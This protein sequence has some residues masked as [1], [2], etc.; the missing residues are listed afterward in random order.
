MMIPR[1]V[2]DGVVAG[3]LDL[4]FRRW[5]RRMHVPGG[6]QRTSVGVISFDEVDVVEADAITEDDARRA[7]MELARLARS[8]PASPA[9]STGSR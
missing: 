9:R 8:W 6:T 1:A 3:Q 7:G 5:T 4:A 2:L